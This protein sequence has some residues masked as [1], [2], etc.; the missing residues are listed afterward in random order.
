MTAPTVVILAA[1]QGTRMHSATPKM[2]HELCGRPLVEWPIRAALDAGAGKV[3]V[4]GG[5]DGE[6]DGALPDGVEL[7]VQAEPRGTGDA[8]RTAVE[9]FDG[10]GTVLVLN[11]A[12][13]LVT[14]QII[15][16]LAEEHART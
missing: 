10:D 7:A 4:V 1:G 3:V 14:P 9:R 15:A 12:T 8:V 5:P 16:A 2:L 13:P 11:G 6:L